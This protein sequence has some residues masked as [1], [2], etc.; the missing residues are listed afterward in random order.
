MYLVYVDSARGFSMVD[1][2]TQA[3]NESRDAKPSSP[4]VGLNEESVWF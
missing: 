3:Q 1:E 2:S 4:L